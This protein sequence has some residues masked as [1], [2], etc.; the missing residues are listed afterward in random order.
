[1]QDFYS[2]QFSEESSGPLLAVLGALD[3][4]R[5]AAELA[6]VQVRGSPTRRGGW[7]E[8]WLWLEGCCRCL[9]AEEEEA[10][11]LFTIASGP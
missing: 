8:H 11:S 2:E 6:R 7:A 4:E 10:R 5:V 1:M 3:G 9:V